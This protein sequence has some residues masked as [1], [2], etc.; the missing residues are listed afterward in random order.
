MQGKERKAP[1]GGEKRES[2]RA[3]KGCPRRFSL[4]VPALATRARGRE[5]SHK[6]I[7]DLKGRNV[8]KAKGGA[9]YRANPG[10]CGGNR[11]FRTLAE[12]RGELKGSVVDERSE[13]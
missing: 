4:T 6:K 1:E 12:G 13:L 3:K 2:G 11:H 5:R 7:S 8:R 10:S 9:S